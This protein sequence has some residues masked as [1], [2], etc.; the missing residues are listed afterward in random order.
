MTETRST[1]SLNPITTWDR[2]KI[3]LAVAFLALM[4]P[5]LF[6][7]AVIARLF[8]L[9]LVFSIL[10]L[11]LNIV[12]G[13]TDQLF[14]FVGA[15]TGL[16][17]YSTALTAEWL[18]V[19]P[20]LTIVPGAIFVGLIGLVVCYVAARRRFTVIL[21]S[22][23][24]LALQFAIIEV[25]TGARGITGG[26]T[27]FPFSG[28]GLESVQNALGLHENYVL[29]YGLLALLTGLL[30]F[31]QWL[32]TSKYGVAFDAIRQDEIAAEAIGID[33]VR[34]KSIAGFV[35]AFIIGF[36][37]PLYAQLEG[38][39]FP[40]L[41]AFTSIDVLVLI[42]LIIGGLRTTLGPVVGACAV[43]MINEELQRYPQWRTVLFGFLL[44]VMFL[45]F[46]Q[47]LVPY[48]DKIERERFGIRD[49][50]AD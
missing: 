35:S 7:Y 10:A 20:W 21:I 41:F 44:I 2:A 46:R 28:L 8:V 26:S 31:Y 12:F 49:R 6:D 16:G 18:G 32:R 27:G 25:F 15:L 9:I 40:G 17:A 23:L 5:L 43:I 33:V 24:T 42:I 3:L 45:Y 39:I 37:G 13:H 4:P 34:Y 30:L 50:F 19:S 47:G 11:A 38:I 14:L 22:I 48:V 1:G 36:V 29:Y